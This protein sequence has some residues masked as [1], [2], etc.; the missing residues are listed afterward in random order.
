M[1]AERHSVRAD[2]AVDLGYDAHIGAYTWTMPRRRRGDLRSLEMEILEVMLDFTMR[3][4]PAHGYVIRKHLTR[5]IGDGTVYRALIRL[6]E[7]SLVESSLEAAEEAERQHRPR[8]RLYTVTAVG[9]QALAELHR[10]GSTSV[11]LAPA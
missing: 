6:E 5:S 11:S 1:I 7:L 9:S 2:A 4:E 3:E 10:V 8:R